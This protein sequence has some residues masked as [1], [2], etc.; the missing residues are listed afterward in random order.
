[1]KGKARLGSAGFGISQVQSGWATLI[2]GKV[3]HRLDQVC[4][5]VRFRGVNSG[6]VM[7]N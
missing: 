2:Y 5:W 3:G 1:M 6:W 4:G 7:L